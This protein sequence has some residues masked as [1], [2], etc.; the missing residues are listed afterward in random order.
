[1]I[2]LAYFSDLDNIKKLAEACAQ[3][4]ISRKIFQWNEHYP[5]RETFEKDIMNRELYVA[6]IDNSIVGCIMFSKLKD[7]VYNEIEWLTP[8]LNNLYI[9]R[10]AV[11]PKNQKKGLA[12]SMMD[13]A[14][15]EAIKMNC[16]SVRL[17]TFSQNQ[18]NSKFYNSRDY[19]QLG[20]VYFPKQSEY[21]FYCF[22]KIMKHYE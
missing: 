19:I 21:P 8:D 20:D 22:E 7:E 4:M 18:R 14:E 9:H 13:F 6:E 5:S 15:E 12:R 11:Y 17:D 3:E 1:M 16:V 10:L 2:R